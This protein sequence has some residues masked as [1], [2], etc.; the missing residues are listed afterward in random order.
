MDLMLKSIINYVSRRS[1]VDLSGYRENYLKRRIDFR[2]KLLGLED[3]LK[4][5][6]LL[7]NNEK[8]VFEL[9]NT[10]TINVTEF[11]R[12]VTP[13]QFFMKRILPEIAEKKKKIGS[14]TLRF[15]SAG[16]SYG[17][18]AYSIVICALEALGNNWS[19]IVYGTDI[20]ENCLKK[21]KEGFYR[22]EQLKNLSKNIID[23]YFEKEENGYRVKNSLK[24]YVKFKR[25][26]LTRDEPISKYLDTIF[27]RNVMIYFT[28]SQKIKVIND[29]YNSLIGGGYLII[30]KSETLPAMFRDRFI[31]VNLKDK[32]YKK[33]NNKF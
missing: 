8:E 27:C 29:F 20:D 26:D 24:K 28:E 13:F 7:Q 19:I 11:M 16:C 21:A 32:I 6:R 30:G 31:A 14:K 4:Y 9:L 15:W 18:E 33:N 2:M 1:G 23:K 25:H 22:S 10:I 3:Y 5:F 12:D 17:E